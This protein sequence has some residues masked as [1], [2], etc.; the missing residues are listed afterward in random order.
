[1]EC[2]YNTKIQELF[3]IISSIIICFLFC[4]IKIH[5]TGKGHMPFN[6][7]LS[8]PVRRD[9]SQTINE[10]RQRNEES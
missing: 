9:S 7:A 2:K 1:M 3:H 4:H 8:L 6:S 10:D 5:L